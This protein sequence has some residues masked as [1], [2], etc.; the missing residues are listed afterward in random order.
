MTEKEINTKIAIWL[1]VTPSVDYS[2]HHPTQDALCFS[3]W[4]RGECE[5][6]LSDIQAEYPDSPYAKYE[7]RRHE[8][9]PPYVHDDAL[10]VGLL[11]EMVQ[12]GYSVI[13]SGH[14]LETGWVIEVTD[15]A[16]IDFCRHKPTIADV[17]CTAVVQLIESI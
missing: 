3:D 11:T 15:G 13:L 7:V 10:A 2:V 12:R 17:I 5:K 6:W 14:P 16:K 9:Y 1:G 8:K 4:S